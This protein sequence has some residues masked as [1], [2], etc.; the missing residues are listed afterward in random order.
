MPF[1]HQ[2]EGLG[3]GVWL[4]AHWLATAFLVLL[5]FAASP[6]EWTLGWLVLALIAAPIVG[7]ILALFALFIPAD[8]YIVGGASYV[9]FGLLFVWAFLDG[10]CYFAL[11]RRREGKPLLGRILACCGTLALVGTWVF[12]G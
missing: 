10:L 12:G 1:S 4:A 7:P 11:D 3:C 6:G 8:A 5:A 2:D 9:G